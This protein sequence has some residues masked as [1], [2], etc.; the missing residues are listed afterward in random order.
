[1]SVGACGAVPPGVVAGFPTLVL[2]VF[3]ANTFFAATITKNNKTR[4]NIVFFII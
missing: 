1:M 2:T 4:N 3:W